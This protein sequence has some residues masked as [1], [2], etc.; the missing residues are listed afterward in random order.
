MAGLSESA[1]DSNAYMRRTFPD[2]WVALR[3]QDM[4]FFCF[5]QIAQ[6]N[7]KRE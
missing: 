6:F 4:R 3:F 7:V 5:C 1:G 2:R